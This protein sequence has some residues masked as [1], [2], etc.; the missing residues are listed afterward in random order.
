M[1]SSWMPW[2]KKA[3]SLCELKFWNGRT[4]IDLLS[5]GRAGVVPCTLAPVVDG[6]V[7]VEMCGAFWR[8]KNHAAPARTMAASAA[9]NQGFDRPVETA[10]TG[11]GATFSGWP[12]ANFAGNAAFPASSV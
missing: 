11:F 2:A 7:L 10:I 8:A 9:I 4:A 5:I 12:A 3:F 6:G 1:I